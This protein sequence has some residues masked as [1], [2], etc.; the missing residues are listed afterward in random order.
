MRILITGSGGLIGG[1]LAQAFLSDGHTI[2]ATYRKTAPRVTEASGRLHAVQADLAESCDVLAPADVVVHAAAHTH[3]VPNS[4]ARDYVRTNLLGTL[5]LVDYAKAVRPK[6]FIYLSTIS[7][8]G[9]VMA[10]E[11]VEETPLHKPELYGATKYAA[12]LMV[13][14]AGE[15]FPTLCVRLPG[16]VGRGYFTPW[17]GQM[18]Q[19]AIRHEPI[20]IYNP[21]ALFNNVID[22][23]ELKR[24]IAHLIDHGVSDCGLVNLATDE[25]MRIREVMQ[26][27]I[28]LTGSRSR[29]LVMGRAEKRSFSISTARLRDRLG[30]HPATTREIIH[31]YVLENLPM[32]AIEGQAPAGGLVSDEA[33]VSLRAGGR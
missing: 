5:N 18:L 8:Y 19:A 29:V 24:F 1:S 3:L 28:S 21:D 9:D 4:T 31:R 2:I 10:G 12:E 26:L 32:S 27:I 15:V 6:L 7:V 13:R 14:E 22:L 30:F 20:R 25:P 33:T 23:Q 17:V 11:L 16:I